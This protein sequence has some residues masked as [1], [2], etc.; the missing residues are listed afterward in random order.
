[1]KEKLFPITRSLTGDGVRQTLKILQQEADFDIN[2]LPTG[3][4]VFDWEVPKEWNIRGARLENEHGVVADMKDTNLRVVGYSEPVNR[5]MAYKEV[6]P[7]LHTHPY[8]IPYRTSYYKRD[9][10]F[11]MTDKEKNK[12]DKNS[13]YYANV[14]STLEQGS[15]TYGEVL[16]PGKSDREYLIT[17]YSCHPSMYNDNVSGMIVWARLLKQMQQEKT[18]HGYHFFIGPETLGVLSLLKRK[19]DFDGALVIN[20]VGRNEDFVLKKSFKESSEV[21]RVALQTFKEMEIRYTTVPFSVN[22]SDERQ[23]SSPSYR[24]PTINI[25]RG[26]YYG[27]DWYHN[28]RDVYHDRTSFLGVGDMEL[29]RSVEVYFNVLMNLDRNHKIFSLQTHGEPM[30]GKRNLYPAT[31][32]KNEAD[33]TA[34]IAKWI[35]HEDGSDLLK[36]AEKTGFD[37]KEISKVYDQLR[38]ERLI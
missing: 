34:T 33:H 1:M 32:G 38:K 23:L 14:D 18:N 17:T 2:E 30:L 4:D 16:L 24:I 35:M 10:G 31:G 29:N 37:M 22:G 8:A 5:E 7:H 15:M 6:E 26:G 19:S 36:V 13:I 11:C 20:C 21:D 25:T 9:L 3:T 27:T 12:L 28:S